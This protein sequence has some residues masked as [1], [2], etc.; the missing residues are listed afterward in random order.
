MAKLK[1]VTN[2]KGEKVPFYAADGIG[3]MRHGGFCSKKMPMYTN[4]PNTMQGRILMDGGL[5]NAYMGRTVMK[6]DK[7]SNARDY[8]CGGIHKR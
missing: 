7:I 8:R 1:M 3:K 5:V 6:G 2:K 4:N